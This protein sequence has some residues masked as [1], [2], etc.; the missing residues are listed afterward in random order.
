M[1]GAVAFAGLNFVHESHGG[2][3]CNTACAIICSLGR[4][5]GYRYNKSLI[6]RLYCGEDDRNLVQSCDNM[7]L[8]MID[9]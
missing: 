8:Y 5:L 6:N 9:K 1:C 7:Q 4:K 2:F 3:S